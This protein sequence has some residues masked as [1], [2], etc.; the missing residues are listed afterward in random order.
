MITDRPA[1][2]PQFQ[3]AIV[4]EALNFV[5][6]VAV[7]SDPTVQEEHQ[8]GLADIEAG[9]GVSLEQLREQLGIKQ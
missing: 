3:Q 1:I 5:V 4:R 9:K 7:L 2:A 6:K 8:R